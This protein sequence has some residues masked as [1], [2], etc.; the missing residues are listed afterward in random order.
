MVDTTMVEMEP[1]FEIIVEVFIVEAVR[2][3]VLTVTKLAVA[4]ALVVFMFPVRLRVL[5]FAVLTELMTAVLMLLVVMPDACMMVEV[6][7]APLLVGQEMKPVGL[8]L[9]RLPVMFIDDR[10]RLEESGAG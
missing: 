5:K 9:V 8:R 3:D 7:G 4:S 2:V 1:P 6:Y 10:V